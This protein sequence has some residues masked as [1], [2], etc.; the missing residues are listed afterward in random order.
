VIAASV[1]PMRRAVPLLAT[2][3]LAAASVASAG[4]HHDGAPPNPAG[5]P[6]TT[7]P[8]DAPAAGMEGVDA[9]DTVVYAEDDG[10]TFDL[11]AGGTLTFRLASHSGTGFVWRPASLEGG[12]LTPVGERTSDASSVAPGAPRM[13]VYRFVARSSGTMGVE[14]DYERPWANQLPVK[15]VRVMVNVR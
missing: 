11:V 14:M 4:C 13:D 5:P 7:T 3:V 15:T 6:D 8:E 12:V 9:A 1:C 10:R 2:R